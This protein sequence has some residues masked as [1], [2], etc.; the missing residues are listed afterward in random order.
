MLKYHFN[1]RGY[2]VVDLFDIICGG[3]IKQL[4]GKEN[5]VQWDA[6][7]AISN[8]DSKRIYFVETK[9]NDILG[10][11]KSLQ[12]RMSKTIELMAD[13]K[14]TDVNEIKNDNVYVQ[15]AYLKR[16]IDYEIVTCY[17]SHS[18]GTWIIEGLMTLKDNLGIKVEYIE[19]GNAFSLKVV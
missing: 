2:R 13:L 12:N 14:I 3:I 16:F 17:A 15:R 6:M 9:S 19:V 4:N 10:D 8:E 11:K 1:Y 18:I 7:I 5:L